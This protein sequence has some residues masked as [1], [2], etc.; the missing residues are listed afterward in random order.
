[1]GAWWQNL[2][3]VH[4]SQSMTCNVQLQCAAATCGGA[5]CG[6]KFHCDCGTHFGSNLRCACVQCIL[7]LA[8]CDQNIPIMKEIGFLLVSVTIL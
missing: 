4:N 6:S 3:L 2:R 7:R 8:K 1:M 5:M